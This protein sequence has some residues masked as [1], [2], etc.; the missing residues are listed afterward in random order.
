MR[1]YFVSTV[2]LDEVLVCEYTSEQEDRRLGQ[3]KVILRLPPSD[4]SIFNRF[5]RLTA[6]PVPG[7]TG[8]RL[9]LLKQ[10]F[11][12]LVVAGDCRGAFYEN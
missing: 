9:I 4:G 7:K 6:L 11:S 2:G 12:N 1:G 5:E 10:A 3:F 8:D